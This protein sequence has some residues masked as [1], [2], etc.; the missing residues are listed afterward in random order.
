MDDVT[1]VVEIEQI[2]QLKHRYFRGVD[3]KDWALLATVFH[4][5]FEGDFRGSTTDP[6]T[7]FNPTPEATGE[8]LHG[9]DATIESF[10]VACSYFN[11]VHFGHNPEIE[12]TGEDSARGLWAMDDCLRFHEGDLAELHGYGHYHETYVKVG[13]QWQIRTTRLTRMRVDITMR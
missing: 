11:S 4:E 8:V 2:K 3:T 5:D 13:G 1:K 9:R 10:K 7:G 6:A 12:I